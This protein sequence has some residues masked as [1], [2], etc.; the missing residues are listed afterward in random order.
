MSNPI[1]QTS[2]SKWS[3]KTAIVIHRGR[4]EGPRADEA[5]RAVARE[6]STEP[7]GFQSRPLLAPAYPGLA[8]STDLRRCARRLFEDGVEAM[9]EQY[10]RHRN[11]L[12]R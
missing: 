7:F 2:A 3:R 12:S 11:G 6:L 5:N 8:E 1:D 10:R 9:E 4:F